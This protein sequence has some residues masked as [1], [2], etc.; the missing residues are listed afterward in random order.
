M[1]KTK[2]NAAGVPLGFIH[3][4]LMKQAEKLPPSRAGE[5]YHTRTAG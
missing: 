3:I 1:D 4:L 2:G 5:Q